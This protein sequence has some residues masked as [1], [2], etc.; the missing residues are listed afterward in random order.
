MSG[1]LLPVGEPF[2]AGVRGLVA[3]VF[4]ARVLLVA[5]DGSGAGCRPAVVFR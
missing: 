5:A 2:T 3:G 1:E 4:G